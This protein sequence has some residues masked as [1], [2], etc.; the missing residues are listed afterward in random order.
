MRMVDLIEKK[1]DGGCLTAEE[2]A[3]FVDGITHGRIPDYQATA[4][5]MAVYFRGLNREE[6]VALT[7]EM[8]RSGSRADL[9]E[10]GGVTV[11]KHSTGGVGDKTTLIVA[12]IAAALG[13]KVAK[14]SGRGLGH[15]GGTVDKLESIPGFRTTLSPD[16]FLEQVRTIGL[17]VV[18]QSGNFAPAD[19]KLYALRDV[20]ATVDETSL[21]AA[22]IMSKKLAAGADCIVLDVKVGSGA[23]M[24]TSAQ[25]ESL[26]RI[27]VEI[28]KAEGRRMRALITN[29]DVPLGRAIGNALEIKEAIQTLRMEGPQDL[30]ALCVALASHMVQLGTERPLEECETDV[31]RV[32]A[33]GKALEKLRE[34]VEAQGGDPA[35]I[36]KP[37]RLPRALHTAP[38]IAPRD[39]FI[40]AMDSKEIGVAA[41]LLGAGRLTAE[42]AI[43]PAAGITLIKTVGDAVRQGEPIATLHFD[44]EHRLSAAQAQFLSAI[45]VENEKPKDQPLIYGIL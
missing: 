17:C 39:G 16:E 1:R 8:T 29:M 9:S 44:E 25:A 42:D 27:M 36:L 19:K 15:T 23:F 35:C 34:M 28:G 24:K 40:T 13:C 41:G 14:M 11:D 3:F 10:C 45:T 38:V 22:S 31:R 20:T 33:N 37:N 18:G 2:I 32:L 6:T 5:M 26:A 4:L 30:T 43:Q 12:P 7:R 21:I